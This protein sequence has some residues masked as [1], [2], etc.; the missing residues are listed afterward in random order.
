[1]PVAVERAKAYVTMAIRH[2]LSMGKGYG[3]TNH[4]YDVYR[5]GLTNGAEIE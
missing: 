2:A 5:N 3:P 1:M 4:F